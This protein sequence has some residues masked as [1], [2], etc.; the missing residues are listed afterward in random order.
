MGHALHRLHSFEPAPED[1]HGLTARIMAAVHAP[2]TSR[3]P[4]RAGGIVEWLIAVA[5]PRPVRFAAA[6][7]AVVLLG[8]FFSQVAFTVDQVRRLEEKMADRAAPAVR[9]TVEYSVRIDDARQVL[10][11]DRVGR[12]AGNLPATRRDGFLVVNGTTVMELKE[13]MEWSSFSR[14]SA[15][16]LPGMG[17][18]AIDRIVRFLHSHAEVNISLGAE[19]V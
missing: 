15:V 2:I 11:V 1:P 17:P 18:D 8:T 19:G 7:L 6:L 4:G 12:L 14:S 9:P 16:S 5:H 10:D 3:V 13:H